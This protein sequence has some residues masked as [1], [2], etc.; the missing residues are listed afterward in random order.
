MS[1]PLNRIL[2]THARRTPVTIGIRREDPQRIWE[3][4]CPLTPEAVHQLIAEKNVRVLVEPCDRRVFS[5][6]E[7]EKAGAT[8]ESNL[9]DAHIIVGIKE[10]P[11]SEL[12]TTPSPAHTHRTHLMFSHTA[13][14]QPYNTPLLS[15]F[16]AP[17]NSEHNPLAPTLIDYELLTDSE[18]GKR[19]VGFGWF[20]GVAGV[21]ESLSSMAHSHLEL[22]IASPFLYTPRPHTLPSLEQLRASLRDIGTR[23]ATDG[24][25]GALGP[26]VIGLTGSG[27]VAQGCLSMLAELPIVHVRVEELHSLVTNPDT[28]LKRI[29]LVH[30]RPEEYLLRTSL[31]L[32]HTLGGAR[33]LNIG[34]ISWRS[35]FL[36]RSSTISDPFYNSHPDALPAHLPG[37]QMMAVDILPA[38]IP[39]DASQHFSDALRPYL[40]AVVDTH[41]GIN[42][43]ETAVLAALERATISQG[44]HLR[45]KH[46]WL[47]GSVDK[48][49]AGNSTTASVGDA[50]T[51]PLHQGDKSVGA[52]KKRR[53]LMLGSGMVAGPAVDEIAKRE[54]VLL[55]IAS[56][57]VEEARTLAGDRAN[58]Q[59]KR[60]DVGDRNSFE[61]LVE[62]ADVVISL[63]P[64]SLH[65]T[66]AELCI[67]HRKHLVTAS[68][69]SKDMQ[70]LHERALQADTLL[71]NEIGLDPGI[72]HCSAI[73]LIS[74]LHAQGK[75]VVPR[76]PLG[77]KFSWSPRGVLSAALNG[78]RFRL[79]GKVH[80]IEGKKLLGDYFPRVPITDEL[81]LE[82]IA[83]RDSLPYAGTY[84][85]DSARTVLRG[86][87]RYPGFSNLMQSFK[88]LGLLETGSTIYLKSW[89]TFVQQ[90]L[91]VQTKDKLDSAGA[92]LAITDVVPKKHLQTLLE[93][94][95]W[96]SITPGGAINA[97]ATPAVPSAP[98]APIDLFATLL[99]HKLRYLP[100]ERDMVVLSHELVTRDIRQPS[101][102][103]EVHTS[104]LIAY[105]IPGGASAMART[106][107]LPVAFAALGVLD[108][109]VRQRGV[110]GPSDASVY[111]P[112]LT[113]LEG[114]GLGV[115]ESVRVG[116]ATTIEGHLVDALD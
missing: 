31:E 116:G 55:V 72:D 103:E 107:G 24:T 43:R 81:Q 9:N 6:S 39:L 73:S 5:V 113:G 110:V 77:Y 64:V 4:R 96:L 66:A 114:V 42:P 67:K 44:G 16:V 29:Y 85:L 62:E 80:E 56:N 61:R 99:A 109:R 90:A 46:R 20:A 91:A 93:A 58:V 104:S 108:G 101:A 34:D 35:Q 78:A 88:H 17:S 2:S 1:R 76:G 92:L 10:T 19:T 94:L 26:I 48:W 28:D 22:G 68:Y 12:V 75:Q 106:V 102:A 50:Q 18:T 21:L 27:N 65:V 23:I 11:L 53:V 54:D 100:H 95:E 97:T 38:T 13:K 115:K 71:L 111:E 15:R 45:E 69:I 32:A 14:G 105:G 74:R 79:Q 49:H 82:G 60:I 25:P 51:K 87:L 59:V 63:L 86:T 30:A 84:N 47:Q 3:R 98:C 33:G 57:S 37:V 52:G 70:A 36:T 8:V 7:F 41:S 83:N 40:D 89:D 112:V